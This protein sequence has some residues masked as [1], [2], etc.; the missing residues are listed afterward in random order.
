M[1]KLNELVG[2]KIVAVKGWSNKKDKYIE[3]MFI[4]FGDGKTILELQEQDYYSYH[5]CSQSARN[6]SL[7]SDKEK[8]DRLIAIT[9]DANSY[10]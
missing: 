5:D 6:L 9:E 3:P 2:L 7:Y 8:Y 4:F 1:S 10:L